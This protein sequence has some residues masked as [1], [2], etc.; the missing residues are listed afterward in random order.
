MK[1]MLTAFH[2]KYGPEIEG[3]EVYVRL[4]GSSHFLIGKILQWDYSLEFV[5][6]ATSRLELMIDMSAVVAIG[7]TPEAGHDS[8]DT[9]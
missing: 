6:I 7:V 2:D 8:N 4:D 9:E 1:R 3:L 5:E